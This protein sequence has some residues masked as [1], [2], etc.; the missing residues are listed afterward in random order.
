MAAIFVFF[1]FALNKP[2]GAVYIASYK[3]PL[4][5]QVAGNSLCSSEVILI[6]DQFRMEQLWLIQHDKKMVSNAIHVVSFC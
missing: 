3:E 5:H 2:P 4:D 6:I 1:F